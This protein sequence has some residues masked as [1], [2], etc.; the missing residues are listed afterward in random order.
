MFHPLPR[1]GL[2]FSLVNSKKPAPRQP[3]PRRGRQPRAK[4][5]AKTAED[6]D[7]EMAV[8]I[9]QTRNASPVLTPRQD[10][11]KESTATAAAAA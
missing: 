1:S 3:A 9:L 7:Q 5:P 10:Y 11:S 4:R 6:L 2:S 8:C